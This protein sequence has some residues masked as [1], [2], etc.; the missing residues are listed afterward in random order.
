MPFLHVIGDVH[1]QYTKLVNLLDKLDAGPKDCIAFVGDLVDHGPQSADVVDRVV[2][3]FPYKNICLV[4]GDHESMMID[5]IK[6]GEP[7]EQW[8]ASGGQATID[9]YGDFWSIP[10]QHKELVKLASPP[11]SFDTLIGDARYTVSHGML[12]PQLD[13]IEGRNS[14]RALWGAPLVGKSNWSKNELLVFGHTVHQEPAW[15]NSNAL[16]I[17]TGAQYEP[18]PLT[19][20]S[21]D[22]T[23]RRQPIVTQS[24][25]R[26]EQRAYN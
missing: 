24:D 19:A 16:C 25:G 17:D 4:M 11:V 1:G 2:S 7:T 12:D 5:S 3:M 8:L 23:R 10:R 6:L 22:L 18:A 15:Y 13:T 14:W 9:S 26:E 21:L 20:V